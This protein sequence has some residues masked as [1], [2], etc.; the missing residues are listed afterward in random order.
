MTAFAPLEF[1]LR[2]IVIG[3][4]MLSPTR[5]SATASP[6]KGRNQLEVETGEW[7]KL[8]R[9][10]GFALARIAAGLAATVG[11]TRLMAGLL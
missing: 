3:L 1:I 6:A 11:I 5:E 10:I 4:N 7:D 8:A 2:A 9:A